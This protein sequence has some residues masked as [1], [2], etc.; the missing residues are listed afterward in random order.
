[1]P[2]TPAADSPD[3]ADFTSDKYQM[4]DNNQVHEN[5]M[6]D[7]I[8]INPHPIRK[9]KTNIGYSTSGTTKNTS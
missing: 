2:I 8:S 4:D 9:L 6:T 7:D 1:M 3:L 5:S